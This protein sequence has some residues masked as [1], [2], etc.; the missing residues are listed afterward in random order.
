[1]VITTYTTCFE[2]DLTAQLVNEWST[3]ESV[4][5]WAD[6]RSITKRNDGKSIRVI[7]TSNEIREISADDVTDLNGD[8]TVTQNELYTEFR[9]KKF[10]IETF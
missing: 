10:P 1:M 2:I 4:T 8:L 5:G 6:I 3:K 7:F 9:G